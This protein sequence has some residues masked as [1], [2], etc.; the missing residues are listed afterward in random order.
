MRDK[1]Y[2]VLF[3]C[4]NKNICKRRKT[5]QQEKPA[6][7]DAIKNSVFKI[8]NVMPLTFVFVYRKNAMFDRSIG[9]YVITEQMWF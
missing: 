6:V 1:Q 2:S 5:Q 9:E 7:L 4:W 3:G 8:I